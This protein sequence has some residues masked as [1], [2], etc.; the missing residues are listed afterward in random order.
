MSQTNL[1]EQ[2]PRPKTVAHRVRA[3]LAWLFYAA[4]LIGGYWLFG[5]AL[6]YGLCQLAGP[7]NCR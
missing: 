7:H 4:I 3:V 1:N 6:A 2:Y 5:V